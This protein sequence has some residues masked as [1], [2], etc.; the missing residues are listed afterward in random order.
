M[1]Q[2]KSKRKRGNVLPFPLALILTVGT[3]CSSSPSTGVPPL[4]G[5]DTCVVLAFENFSL[6]LSGDCLVLGFVAVVVDALP[7][8]EAEVEAEIAGAFGLGGFV[9][10][11]GRRLDVV[12]WV[13]R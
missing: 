6:I 10:L 12:A 5:L 13:V 2:K 9:D 11:E 7:V 4:I 1:V 3:T 8:V